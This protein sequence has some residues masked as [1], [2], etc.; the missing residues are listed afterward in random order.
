MP[1][2]TAGVLGNIFLMFGRAELNL[3]IQNLTL[4]ERSY[5]NS[6]SQMQQDSLEGSYC[7]KK[8]SEIDILTTLS[9]ST[10]K[11]RHVDIVRHGGKVKE[12]M[13]NKSSPRKC[14]LSTELFVLVVWRK[15]VSNTETI[16]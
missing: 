8:D 16:V 4:F 11:N 3:E 1:T 7:H 2:N 9:D 14:E 15:E 12:D 10:P 5:F 13:E 6:A